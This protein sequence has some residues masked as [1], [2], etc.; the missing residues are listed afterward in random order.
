MARFS[1]RRDGIKKKNTDF[2]HLG[3]ISFACAE[4]SERILSNEM[5]QNCVRGNVPRL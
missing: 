3:C 5:H 4:H 1:T 2:L